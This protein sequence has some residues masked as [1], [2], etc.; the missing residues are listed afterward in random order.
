MASDTDKTK[1]D[2]R[3]MVDAKTYRL[4]HR[5]RTVQIHQGRERPLRHQGRH[6]DENFLMCLPDSIEAFNM[7][8]KQW[9]TVAVD[10]LKHVTWNTDAFNSLAVD[11]KTKTLLEALV[12]NKI[13]ANS[14]TDVVTGKGTGLIVLLH[15]GPGTGKTL[16]AESVAEFAKKPLYRITCGDVGT[17]PKEVEKY[18]ESA[19]QLGR[20]WDC[21]VLLDEADVF[22]EQRSF[23]NLE[24]NALVSVFLRVLEYYDGILLLTSNRVGTFDEAFKSRIQLALHYDSLDQGQ[25]EQI[26]TNFINR[27]EHLEVEAD[28][29]GIR[30]KIKTLA[31]RDMNGRQIRNA[32]TTARQLAR[33]EKAPVKYE[34]LVDVIKVSS[35]FEDYLLEVK[36]HVTDAEE[37]REER[38]R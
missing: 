22:L 35:R 27:L 11:Q 2:L 18:L 3:Y 36:D 26:W 23:Q 12:T 15:G 17:N 7:H 29:V 16:T 28:F 38:I 14:G 6:D 30:K 32:I 10:R 34:H 19:F 21:V 5:T 33:H 9:H 25:R 4:V 24:R 20:T 31:S 8:E 13:E 37:K 1:Q